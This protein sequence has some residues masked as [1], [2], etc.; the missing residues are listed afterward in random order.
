[1]SGGVASE[2]SKDHYFFYSLDL[3]VL[4]SFVENCSSLELITKSED[5]L[6]CR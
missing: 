6:L 1:M 4:L 5:Y 2:V 3:M